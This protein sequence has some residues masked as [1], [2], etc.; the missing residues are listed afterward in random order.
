MSQTHEY[1]VVMQIVAFVS[2]TSSVVVL[3]NLL[4]LYLSQHGS[5]GN[6]FTLSLLY[7]VL[8]YISFGDLMG[9]ASYLSE[10]RPRNGS[11]ACNVE[12]FLNIFAYPVSWLWTLYLAYVLY[13]L[14]VYEIM[15]DKMK[16]AHIICWGV[17]LIFAL[18]Q[19]GNGG[20]GRHSDEPYDMCASG[21][22]RQATVYHRITYY[23]LLLLCIIFMFVM[24]IHT[25]YLTYYKK[26]PCT[27]TE[28][29]R[30][31]TET[32]GY[33]PWILVICW[34]P[35]GITRSL[36]HVTAAW[37]VFGICMKIAHGFLLACTYFFQSSHARKIFWQTWNPWFWFHLIT[38]G[39]EE[40]LELSADLFDDGMFRST[41]AT[42]KSTTLRSSLTSKVYIGE[43]PMLMQ[44]RIRGAVGE[45]GRSE[46]L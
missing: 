21:E 26:D 1:E 6:D 20:Y 39:N 25:L 28:S 7:Q 35:H 41:N 16:I 32:L 19:I 4:A 22:G 40:V 18:G 23:G 24:R 42:M 34:I 11:L 10:E 27:L 9:N 38:S 13:Y 5:G 45:Q 2:V 36:K 12:G 3:M 37:Y 30:V 43:N 17:P 15:L 8:A 14:A 31:S 44:G 46:V 33:Y 29:F